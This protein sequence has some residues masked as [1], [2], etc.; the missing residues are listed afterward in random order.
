MKEKLYIK[1]NFLGTSK[2][3]AHHTYKAYKIGDEIHIVYENTIAKEN[4]KTIKQDLDKYL[5]TPYIEWVEFF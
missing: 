4:I 1:E 3:M 2:D 5:W